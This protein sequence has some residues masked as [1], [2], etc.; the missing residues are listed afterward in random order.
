MFKPF[1]LNAFEI[2]SAFQ[3]I[4]PKA[5]PSAEAGGGF[6]AEGL[7]AE[8][9]DTEDDEGEAWMDRTSSRQHA[10]PPS[11]AALEPIHRRGKIISEPVDRA[12]YSAALVHHNQ[13]YRPVVAIIE[14]HGTREVLNVTNVI[15]TTDH[16]GKA[17]FFLKKVGLELD[18][19]SEEQD[20]LE[21]TG[22][23]F[24]IE[25]FDRLTSESVIDH[26]SEENSDHGAGQIEGIAFGVDSEQKGGKVQTLTLFLA[27]CWKG[28]A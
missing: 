20:L 3:A 25:L 19:A 28:L 22:A 26:N 21:L 23:E 6:K 1:R 24:P 11:I 12:S 7:S 18:S 13:H 5:A 14:R 8:E 17:R 9:L 4:P 2:V 10:V 15:S 27:E 16:R